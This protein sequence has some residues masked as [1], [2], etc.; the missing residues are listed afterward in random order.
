MKDIGQLM[1]LRKV[2][3]PRPGW[4]ESRKEWMKTMRGSMP[5][6]HLES[7]LQESQLQSRS[8]HRLKKS[9]REFLEKESM[10]IRVHGR[11]DAFCGAERPV[12]CTTIIKSRS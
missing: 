12:G 10:F 8:Y 6:A 1:K 4:K 9:W 5:V 2:E 3:T 7:I 11:S